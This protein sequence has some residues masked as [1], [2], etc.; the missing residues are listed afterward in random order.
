M[1]TTTPAEPTS[2]EERDHNNP[3]WQGHGDLL[4]IETNLQITF[5]PNNLSPE[6]PEDQ[7]RREWWYKLDSLAPDSVHFLNRNRQPRR[8]HYVRDLRRRR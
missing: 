4:D 2:S 7:V 8:S 5:G 1:R 3:P 6:D